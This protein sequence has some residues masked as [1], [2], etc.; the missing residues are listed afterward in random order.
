MVGIYKITCTQ[1]NKVYIGSS[2]NINQRWCGHRYRLKKNISNP[3]L[4]NSYNKYG[5]S[6]LVFE[7][8]Q[9]CQLE[10]LIEREIYWVNK[11]KEENIELFNTGI[12]VDNPTRGIKF[13]EARIKWHKDYFKTHKNPAEGRK[14]VH[15]GD[16]QKYVKKEELPT[17][18]EVG[19]QLGLCKSHRENISKR[20]KEIG[21]KPSEY[22]ISRL[23]ECGRKPKSKLHIQN[24]KESKTLLIGV[25]VK[26]V[27]TGEIFRSYTEAAEKYNTSYQAIRQSILKNG[28]CAKHKFVKI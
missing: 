24:L 9:E 19:Y 27:E 4:Q 26:C 11:C 20:Q 23:K 2:G 12:F 28:K 3:N 14:W 7:V 10:N 25:K 6:S 13:N 15:K 17:Y 5:L 1:N 16:D 18:L 8:L 21:R 22:N